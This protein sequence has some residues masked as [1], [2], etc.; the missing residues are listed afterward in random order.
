VDFKSSRSFKIFAP[1]SSL[2][3]RTVISL[4]VVRLIL[5]PVL[6]LAVF[7]LFQM[8]LIVDRIVR[9]DAPTARLAERASVAIL[10]ARRAERNYFLLHDVGYLRSNAEAVSRAKAA[11]AQIGHLDSRDRDSTQEGLKYV[12][13]Y[14]SQFAAVK[15]PANESRSAPNRRLETT[16]QA[17][18]AGLNGLLRK[19]NR[20]SRAQLMEELHSWAGRFDAE[21]VKTVEAGDPDLRQ[22]TVDLQA[23]SQGGLRVASELEKLSWTHIESD[24]EEARRLTNRAQWTLSLTS[25]ATLILSIWISFIL[26]RRVVKPLIDLRAAVD[27]AVAGNY[28]IDLEL[29]G[30]GEVVD[31]ARSVRNLIAH[32]RQ[33]NVVNAR[34]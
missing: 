29:S 33:Q 4:A 5:V 25:A 3:R 31:L 22:A 9:L 20:E 1:G 21:I 34:A 24:Y 23:S 10:E 15:S 27:H 28:A 32:V 30:E 12:R 18:E 19:G 17:Y 11:M 6:V 2:R 7:Y 26:P 14:E 16:V 13:L 8:G